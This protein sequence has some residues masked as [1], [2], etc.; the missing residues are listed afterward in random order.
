MGIVVIVKMLRN[1]FYNIEGYIGMNSLVSILFISLGIISSC[2]LEKYTLHI[3][4]WRIFIIFIILSIIYFI[5]IILR[6]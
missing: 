4:Q 6:K 5:Y 3:F 2:N 1:K